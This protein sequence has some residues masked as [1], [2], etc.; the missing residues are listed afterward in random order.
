M[1]DA[2]GN[3]AFFRQQ[4]SASGSLRAYQSDDNKSHNHLMIANV[5][6]GS[7]T[8]WNTGLPYLAQNGSTGDSYYRLQS[9]SSAP[10]VGQTSSSGGTESRPKNIAMNF[11]CRVD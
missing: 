6:G 4:G 10:T 8:S 7:G 5:F 3:S 1:P 9:T 11:Y 2:V